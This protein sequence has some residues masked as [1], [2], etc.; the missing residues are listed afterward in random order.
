MATTDPS[1]LNSDPNRV[2]FA[3][4]PSLSSSIQPS[5]DQSSAQ[6]SAVMCS[7]AQLSPAQPN[8][9]NAF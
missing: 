4:A 1:Q 6:C 2:L 3:Y 8:P 5:P 7:A 9:P